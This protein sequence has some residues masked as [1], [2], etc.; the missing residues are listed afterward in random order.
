VTI[1]LLLWKVADI[2]PPVAQAV[3]S[4]VRMDQAMGLI[5]RTLDAQGKEAER[6]LLKDYFDQLG[7]INRVRNDILFYGAQVH[8]R[9]VAVV[10]N[11]TAA[12]IPDRARETRVSVFDLEQM[13]F[14]LRQIR[15]AISRALV[16]DAPLLSLPRAKPSLQSWR[17]KQP[18]QVALQRMTPTTPVTRSPP[19]ASSQE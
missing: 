11:K 15:H 9:D 3:L 6:S 5:S 1:Q 13:C 19:P 7:V 8:E 18:P 12:H 4:G 14:D 16:V 2:Q 17:Y 10:S